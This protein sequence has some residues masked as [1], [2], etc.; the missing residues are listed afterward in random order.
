MVKPEEKARQVINSMLEAAL[1]QFNEIYQDL[2]NE[3]YT[4]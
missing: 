2:R 3:Y 1:E 4:K